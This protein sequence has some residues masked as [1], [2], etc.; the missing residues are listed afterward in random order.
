[1]IDWVLS[2]SY[3]VDKKPSMVGG[4][5]VVVEDGVEVEPIW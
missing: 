4:A 2:C 3:T 1:M 5:G